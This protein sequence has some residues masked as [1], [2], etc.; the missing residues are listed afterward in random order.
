MLL[1]STLEIKYRYHKLCKAFSKFYRR[2]FDLVSKFTVE[3][4][5]LLQKGLSKLEFYSDLVYKFRKIYACNNLSTQFRKIILRYIKIGYNINA[6]RQT[7][8]MVFRRKKI[9]IK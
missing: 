4:K 6:I 3:F 8:C 1:T 9:I 7:S 5:S 2:H